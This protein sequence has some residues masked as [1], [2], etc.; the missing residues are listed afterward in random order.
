MGGGSEALDASY[1]S[2]TKQRLETRD[3]LFAAALEEFRR[4]GVAAAQ[5][6]NIVRRAGVARGTF[7]LHFPTKDHVLLEHLRRK[8]QVFARKLRGTKVTSVRAFLRRVADLMMEDAR[9]EHPAIWH[10]LVAALSRHAASTRTEAGAVIEVLNEFFA[11][12]QARGEVRSDITPFD[13]SAVFL[14]GVYGL[15]Q[16]KLDAPVSE[17]RPALQRVVDIFARGVAPS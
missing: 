14:P 16:M 15:L 6:E 12:A 9:Q 4:T 11:R 10:E 3:R 7:Y 8:Q 2:R 13:L 1:P 17:L 5:I